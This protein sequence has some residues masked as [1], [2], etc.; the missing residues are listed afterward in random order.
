M[1]R[2][3]REGG[4][5]RRDVENSHEREGFPRSTCVPRRHNEADRLLLDISITMV[6]T[7]SCVTAVPLIDGWNFGRKR[8][9]SGEGERHGR[10][11]A[12]GRGEGG[13]R[14]TGGLISQQCD[15]FALVPGIKNLRL[16]CHCVTKK[17]VIAQ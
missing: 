12:R 4:K 7:P 5:E 16:L 9:K 3:K 10:D 14:G 13:E 17:G 8:G 1:E 6:W 15:L 2:R 11:T